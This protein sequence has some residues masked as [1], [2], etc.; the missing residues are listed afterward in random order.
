MNNIAEQQK[1]AWLIIIGFTLFRV[2]YSSSFL[3]VPDETNYWQ[4][5]R[6]LDWGYHDQAPL[7]AW[8]IWL[9]TLIFGQTE[10]AVRLPS[11]LG[12]GLASAYL[13]AISIRWFGEGVALSTAI[14]T[15]SILEYN[16]GALLATPDGLQ[17]AAWAASAYHVARGYENDEW[18]QWI[19]GGIWFGIGMLAKFTMVIFL[20]CAFLYGI[21][22]HMHRKRL[23]TLKPYTGV[24]VGSLMF[25][26]V[27]LWNYRHGWNSVKHVAG[28]GG[29]HESFSIRW[30]FVGDFVGSQAALLSPLV[31]ILAVW[32]WILVI[33]KDY[34]QQNWLYPYLFWTS[35]PMI[36]FFLLLSFHSRIYGN[37]PGAGYLGAAVLTAAYFGVK[38]SQGLKRSG[39]S[40]WKWAIGISYGMSA[41]VLLH[42]VWPF[43]PV[44]VHLDRAA[45]EIAG[46]D[47]LGEMAGK[48]SS[49]M[50]VPERTF[51]FG[52]S[53]QMASE[54]AFYTPGQ[55][56]TVSIN[57]WGRP[58]VYDYWWKEE[59]R[60]GWDAIGVTYDS[61]ISRER[62]SQIFERVDPPVVLSVFRK[63]TD[64]EP[65]KTFFLYRCYGYALNGR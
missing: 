31:F 6:Y 55:P 62:L 19:T 21:F 44:P 48:L 54:L 38:N 23:C 42:A 60:K 10:M 40:L 41:L 59:D 11:V 16:V 18:S 61:T 46:W 20:P 5:S 4:W 35:F 33:K 52:L 49:E 53:Y 28:L 2:I 29:V 25:F 17:A 37:W 51:L 50:P 24:L 32:A 27:I 56:R 3:L 65:I 30:N 58:N 26:P 8:A 63:K 43:L 47:E 57:R 13:V 1:T 12:L 39:K 15:Q 9:S 7:I 36:A 34:P 45:S 14:L 64:K 22:S